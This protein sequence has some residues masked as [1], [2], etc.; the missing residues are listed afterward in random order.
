MGRSRGRGRDGERDLSILSVVVGN[1]RL[2]GVPSLPAAGDAAQL[3]TS[4]PRGSVPA[5]G[6]A[7]VVRRAQ[8]AGRAGA[9]DRPVTRTLAALLLAWPAYAGDTSALRSSAR[10]CR[11][12]SGAGALHPTPPEPD[13]EL[14]RRVRY[15]GTR[16]PG[17]RPPFNL[18]VAA[19]RFCSATEG[20]GPIAVRSR[21]EDGQPSGTCVPAL[22]VEKTAVV[23]RA[24][25]DRRWG[26][27]APTSRPV[28]STGW[29]GNAA[30]IRFALGLQPDR[31][32]PPTEAECAGA[33]HV[34]RRGG[35]GRQSFSAS[36]FSGRPK[37]AHNQGSPTDR[38][39]GREWLTN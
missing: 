8:V 13:A 33:R 25:E 29:D 12:G 32:R 38:L 2:R 4:R 22:T 20:A 7:P 23:Q 3:H 6:A 35:S 39:G 10:S 14:E 1:P 31:V 30:R 16:I 34:K 11:N 17:S 36:A 37:H 28:T 24:L 21:I 9:R 19:W 27:Q 5:N 26:S 18:S 15:P